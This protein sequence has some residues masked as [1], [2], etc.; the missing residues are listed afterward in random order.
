M[1]L[2]ANHGALGTVPGEAS[3]PEGGEFGLSEGR[4]V[5]VPNSSERAVERSERSA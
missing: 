5:R 3:V 2:G 1:S 4:E